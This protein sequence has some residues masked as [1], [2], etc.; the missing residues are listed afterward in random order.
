[1]LFLDPLQLFLLDLLV[2]DIDDFQLLLD[3]FDLPLL[4]GSIYALL[5]H[6]VEMPNLLLFACPL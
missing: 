1:M 3:F 5:L 4:L 2:K 6:L